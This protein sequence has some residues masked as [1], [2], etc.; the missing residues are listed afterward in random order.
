VSTY[1][2]LNVH[3]EENVQIDDITALNADLSKTSVIEILEDIE[4]IEQ[5][6]NN[7][8]AYDGETIDFIMIDSGKIKFA[9]IDDGHVYTGHVSE[10]VLVWSCFHLDEMKI[11]ARHMTTGKLVLRLEADGYADEYFVLTPNKVE[12]AKITF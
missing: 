1:T 7:Y 10:Y 6:P 9:S 4:Y 12:K 5:G 2:Y 8:V 11:L 3:Q